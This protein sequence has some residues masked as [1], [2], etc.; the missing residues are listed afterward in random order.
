MR[1]ILAGV[2]NWFRG[3][4]RAGR[5]AGATASYPPFGPAAPRGG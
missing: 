5:H 1:D 2:C 4:G 3:A